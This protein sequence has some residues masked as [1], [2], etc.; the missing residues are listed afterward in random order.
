MRRRV[1][2]LEPLAPDEGN[3]EEGEEPER[4]HAH[5]A[6]LGLVQDELARVQLLDEAVLVEPARGVLV[7][8]DRV[9]IVGGRRATRGGNHSRPRT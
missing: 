6:G 1:D 7:D 3:A 8:E 4:A 5:E 9:R 2:A